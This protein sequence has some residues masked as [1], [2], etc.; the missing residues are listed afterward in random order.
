ML[1]KD[2]YVLLLTEVITN[3]LKEEGDQ[4]RTKLTG[5]GYR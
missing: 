3:K 2:T 1:Q 4:V 5:K